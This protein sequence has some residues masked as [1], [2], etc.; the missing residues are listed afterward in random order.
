MIF[1]KCRKNRMVIMFV[2]LLN[3]IVSFSFLPMKISANENSDSVSDN[4]LSND[5][6]DKLLIQENEMQSESSTIIASGSRGENQE[7]TWTLDTDGLLYVYGTGDNID[8][9]YLAYYTNRADLIK[10]AKIQ[11]SGSFYLT[12]MF[13]D[14]SSLEEVDFMNSNYK[15]LSLYNIFYNCL[16]L[17][18]I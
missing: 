2:F 17:K 16:N 3:V 4:Q 8:L 5:E 7:I 1:C 9:S 18:T 11:I 13:Y 12:G 10:S 14:C 15:A 6:S